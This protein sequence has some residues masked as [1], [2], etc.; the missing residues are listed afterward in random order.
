MQLIDT[1]THLYCEEFDEDR[2]EVIQRA[3]EAGVTTMLL[4]AID[5]KSYDRQEQLSQQY[6]GV[7]HQMM[8]LHPTSIDQDY[9]KKLSICRE[10]L[11][12]NPDK[13]IGIGEIGLDSYWDTSFEK[14]QSLALREQLNWAL[15]LGKPVDLH[16]RNCY[17]EIFEILQES[18]YER[19]SGIFHCFSGSLEQAIKAIEMGFMI[20]I[21]GV[22]SFKKSELP[23]IVE[24]IPLEKIVLE[25]DSPYLAPVPHRGKRNESAYILQVAQKIAELKNITLFEVAHQTS[26]NAR[27]IFNI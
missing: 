11:F 5:E 8:G 18:D 21:G 22:V 23:K 10:L 3:I 2:Q 4:P 7:F 20:G 16:I 14:E 17:K 12:S 1:H 19:I 26:T 6:P 13:Y 9:Q 15:E 25:T 27:S 24:A